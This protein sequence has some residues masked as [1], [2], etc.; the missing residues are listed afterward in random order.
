MKSGEAN[1][2]R[3]AKPT[4]LPPKKPLRDAERL[5]LVKR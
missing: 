4:D 5:S 2:W 1:Y 3:E